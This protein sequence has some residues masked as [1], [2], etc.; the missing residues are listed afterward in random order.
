MTN[1]GYQSMRNLQARNSLNLDLYSP[2]HNHKS[3]LETQSKGTKVMVNAK[4][5]QIPIVHVA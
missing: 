4:Y 5:K 3:L 1:T 2:K